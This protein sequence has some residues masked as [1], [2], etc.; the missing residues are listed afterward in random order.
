VKVRSLDGRS[1]AVPGAPFSSIWPVLSPEVIAGVY[2]AS[3]SPDMMS[4]AA[5]R[6][7]NSI[8]CWLSHN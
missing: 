8:L 2:S 7:S 5:D 6:T 1:S 4:V 3:R